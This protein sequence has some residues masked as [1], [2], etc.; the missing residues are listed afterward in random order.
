MTPTYA[1]GKAI[2]FIKLV[3][4]EYTNLL[5]NVRTKCRTIPLIRTDRNHRRLPFYLI[6]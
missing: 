2:V 4:N 3:L 1:Q 5:Q 6:E